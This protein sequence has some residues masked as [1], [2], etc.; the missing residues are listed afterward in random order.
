MK[1]ESLSFFEELINSHSPSGYEADAAI[2]WKKR[3]SEFVDKIKTDVHGNTLAI[4]NENGGPVVM[5]AGHI[6]EIGYMVKYIDKEGFVYFA[7]IGGVDMHLV[8]GQR[9]WIKT[10]KG[11]V[12]GVVG[13]KPIHCQTAEERK[14]VSKVEDLWIDI[15][16]KSDKEAM[17]MVNVGDP[18]VPAVG[19]DVLKGDR[20]TGR[21][22]DDRA[23]AFCVSECMRL[24]KGKKI[25]AAVYGVATVQEELGL[26]GGRTSAYGI[27]PDIGIAIDVTFC[28]DVPGMNKKQIGDIKLGGGPVIARGPNINHK[29]FDLLVKTAKE[30][31]IPYQ[32]EGI[33]RATGTDANVIQLTRAGVAAGLVS[34]P[35]RYMHSPVEM[36]DLGDIEKVSKLL[37]GFIKKIKKTTNFLP[38]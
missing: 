14:R 11:D 26:R 33:S 8:P 7:P 28:T 5:L 38:Y 20:V 4:T 31:K 6:D 23:G 15:G 1:G 13:R 24:L 36:V 30:E 3:T 25:D 37:S 19:F 21:G 12:F 16:A 10:D 35:N 32:V 2:L 18:A 9:V 22:F 17:K 29:V 34:I 27:N